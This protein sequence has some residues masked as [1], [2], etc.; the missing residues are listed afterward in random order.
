MSEIRNS[1]NNIKNNVYKKDEKVRT[2]EDLVVLINKKNKTEEDIELIERLKSYTESMIQA[3]NDLGTKSVV[4]STKIDSFQEGLEIDSEENIENHI[5]EIVLIIERFVD[6]LSALIRSYDF[7]TEY[8]QL[9]K[10]EQYIKS[11]RSKL[12]KKL[13]EFKLKN[14]I[15]Q[16]DEKQIYIFVNDVIDVMIKESYKLRLKKLHE[17]LSRDYS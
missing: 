13:H 6:S 15:N 10:T 17:V 4:L 12:I 8:F 1:F 14:I 11:Y 5:K 9:K 3:L 2:L 7:K 16:E